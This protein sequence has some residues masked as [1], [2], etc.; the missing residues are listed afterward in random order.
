[1]LLTTENLCNVKD[2]TFKRNIRIP[3]L[4]GLT[5]STDPDIQ[6][7]LIH[8]ENEYD[9][10]F[11]CKKRMK[12]FK[13][14]KECYFALMNKNLPVYGVPG[15]LDEYLTTKSDLKKGEQR[16]PPQKYLCID[17]EAFMPIKEESPILLTDSLEIDDKLPEKD[18]PEL[19]LMTLY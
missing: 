3:S 11:V 19:H 13:A 16:L 12:L 14:I 17:E 8:V 2:G 7:F 10:E 9:Y 1:M 18:N 6:N 15:Q 5:K 4:K